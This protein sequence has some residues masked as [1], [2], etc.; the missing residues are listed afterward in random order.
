MF[1]LYTYSKCPNSLRTGHTLI[2]LIQHF[3]FWTVKSLVGLQSG[4]GWSREHIKKQLSSIWQ[5]LKSKLINC[6]LFAKVAESVSKLVNTLQTVMGLN[7][8]SVFG[9]CTF[10]DRSACAHYHRNLGK[11]INVAIILCYVMLV[12]FQWQCC[13][14]YDVLNRN[15][16]KSFVLPV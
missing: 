5:N 9:W 8:S 6:V 15:A 14:C 16:P 1:S 10:C 11:K 3:L 2:Y 4:V 13:M 12:L 7:I